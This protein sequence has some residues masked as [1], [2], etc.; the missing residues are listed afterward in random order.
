[1]AAGERYANVLLRWVEAAEEDE[2]D[3]VAKG[4]L[5]A[6]ALVATEPGVDI[7]LRR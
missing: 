2:E 4:V 5:A 6:E 7:A 1:M 3:G